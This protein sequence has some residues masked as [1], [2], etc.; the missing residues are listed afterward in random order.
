VRLCN[1]RPIIGQTVYNAGFNYFV[2][3][4]LKY[5]F[6]PSIF[7]G[8]IIRYTPGAALMSDG[9]VQAGQSGGPMFNANG[10]LMGICVSN[11]KAYKTIYPNINTA[12]PIHEIKTIL[13]DFA[14]TNGNSLTDQYHRLTIISCFVYRCWSFK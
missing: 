14:K 1:N 7:Q 6:N 9:C 13:E 12:V 4:H 3:F 8:R 5:D 10:H 11:I 2:N